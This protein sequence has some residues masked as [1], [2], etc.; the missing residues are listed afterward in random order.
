MSYIVQEMND[1]KKRRAANLQKWPLAQSSLAPALSGFSF[2]PVVE[3]DVEWSMIALRYLGLVF[4]S[5]LGARESWRRDLRAPDSP[6]RILLGP[7]HN[8]DTLYSVDVYRPSRCSK[9]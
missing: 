2:V 1:D 6:Y 4:S 7:A 5:G 8:S 3:A 9:R